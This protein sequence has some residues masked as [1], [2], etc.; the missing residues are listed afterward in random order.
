MKAR[1]YKTFLPQV[2]QDHESY[3]EQCRETFERYR[4]CYNIDF[5]RGEEYRRDTL[6]I[7]VADANSYVEGYIASLFSKAPAVR[8][9]NDIKATSGDEN[10][11]EAVTNRFLFDQQEPFT[12]ACRL[13]LIYP[14][15][16]IK[17]IP[18]SNETDIL[19][20]FSLLTLKPW[21]V[22]VDM[23]QSSWNTCRWVGH[24][25]YMPVS[26]AREMFGDKKYNATAASDY[27]CNQKKTGN[28]ANIPDDFLYIKLVEFYDL[29]NSKRIFYT[30]NLTTNDGI[31]EIAD[32]PMVDENNRPLAPIIPLYLCTTPEQ[33]LKGFS[34]IKKIYDQIREKNLIRTHMASSIRRDTR[35]YIYQKGKL[36][37]E[38]LAKIETGMDNTMVAVDTVDDVRGILA[39]VQTLP[40]SSNYAVH[41]QLVEQDLARSSVLAPFTRG[42]ATKATATEVNALAQYT[43]AEV[44]KMARQRDGAIEAVAKIYIKML[45]AFLDEEEEKTVLTINGQLKTLTAKDLQ[46]K[47]RIVAVDQL[48]S[49]QAQANRKQ[50]I[51]Q[52]L[53]TLVQLGVP[54]EEL[55]KQLGDAF[56][57]D[58]LSTMETPPPA[59]Q[60]PPQ[61]TDTTLPPGAP[62]MAPG[63]V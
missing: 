14:M 37:E 48:S 31:L 62:I 56:G 39:P 54:Q 3:Y 50:E 32:I 7:Q 15:A 59:P 25:S 61:G 55:R 57:W 21:E 11:A 51:V 30:P 58:W 28:L 2:L 17:I 12:N 8:I 10:T 22:I 16:F 4:D 35:Q 44:G 1:D 34:T 53:P 6:T 24:V 33:P 29:V 19:N 40:V 41:L 46:G 49:P 47:F 26:V 45:E 36:D 63:P 42:E 13:A 20:Q 18:T 27:F 60:L 52:M 43:A 9:G 5:F 38:A 23:Q